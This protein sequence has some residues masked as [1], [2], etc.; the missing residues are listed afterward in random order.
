MICGG[1]VFRI[2]LIFAVLEEVFI[3]SLLVIFLVKIK[4][5]IWLLVTSSLYLL[6]ACTNPCL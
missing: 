2:L 4:D 1:F 5:E 3:L 6:I